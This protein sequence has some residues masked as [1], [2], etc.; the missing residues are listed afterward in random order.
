MRTPTFVCGGA[1]GPANR[2]KLLY[3][4][5]AVADWYATFAALA[6]VSPHQMVSESNRAQSFGLP[7]PESMDLY[8]LISGPSGVS[9][10]TEIV[11][12]H[13]VRPH[14]ICHGL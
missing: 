12:D 4:L 7:P 5:A 13:H 11:L 9:P 1:V 10:R 8:E 6:G 2:G 3:G 14:A